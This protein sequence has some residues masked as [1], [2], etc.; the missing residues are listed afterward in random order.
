[1]TA[2]LVQYP[3]MIVFPILLGWWLRRRFG[4]GWS[5]F[6]IG[7]ATLILS[8]VV[9][10]PL[11]YAL[12]LIGG[13]RGVALWPLVPLALVAGLSA[14]VCEEGARW[15]VLRFWAKKARSWA[16]GLQ[17]G[18]G[19]GGAEAIIFGLL[20]ALSLV[21]MIA[22]RSLDP[23]ALNLAGATADQVRAALVQYWQ[24]PWYMA[25]LAGLERVFAI[26]F[27]IAMALLVVRSVTQGQAGKHIA[28]VG[29]L[30]AAIG[31][32]TLLDFWAVWGSKALGILPVYGGLVILAAGAFWLIL[33][34]RQEPVTPAVAPP[35]A[36]VAPTTA[37]LP[38]RALSIEELARRADASK[39]E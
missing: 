6:L 21:S 10:L 24:T 4:V 18:A 22:L 29:W 32:H 33:F 20:A 13:G 7:A 34:L 9:H 25:A 26:T 31:A 39:Y 37:D 27:Q 30:L 8:Q 3:L 28:C 38:P 35:P 16:A 5:I 11:N 36:V 17:F 2:L 12:G 19:H 14:G 15:L 23:A 1:L